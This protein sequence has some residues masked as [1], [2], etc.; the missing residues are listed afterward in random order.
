ELS[1]SLGFAVRPLYGTLLQIDIPLRGSSAVERERSL[2]PLI[3]ECLERLRSF[4]D[5]FARVGVV[6]IADEEWAHP[7][8]AI[9]TLTS[10]FPSDNGSDPIGFILRAFTSRVEDRK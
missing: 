1:A 6:Y 7:S 5:L 4:D 9:Q 2:R 10:D 3:E 8:F